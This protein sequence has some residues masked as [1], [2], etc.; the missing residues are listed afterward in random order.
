MFNKSEMPAIIKNRLFIVFLAVLALVLVLHLTHLR[1]IL[2]D[3]DLLEEALAGAG[4]WAPLVFVGL[5][6]VSVALGCP[7]LLVCALGGALFGF[8]P[9]LLYSLIGTV[10]GSYT[11]FLLSRWGR[12]QSSWQWPDRLQRML[13]VLERRPVLGV[14]IL[15]Q[16]PITGVVTNLFLGCTRVGQ[17]AFVMGSLIGYLPTAIPAA[18]LGQGVFEASILGSLSLIAAAVIL[19]LVLSGLVILTSRRAGVGKGV[20]GEGNGLPFEPGHAEE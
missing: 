14:V 6:V 17:G 11:V 12:R 20:P 5:S 10:G 16:T 3:R 4:I 8:A 2:L 13:R 19:L 9:G 18:L 1:E 15:R 7:R